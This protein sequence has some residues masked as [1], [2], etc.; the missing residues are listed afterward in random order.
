M[1]FSMRWLNDPEVNQYLETKWSDQTTDSIRSS[2]Q[3][4]R[5][6][7]QSFL[8]AI[9][10]KATD[11]HIR[12]IKIGPIHPHYKHADISCFIG[13]KGFWHRGNATEAIGL[14]CKYGFEQL[15]L[16]RIEA[17]AYACAVASWKALEKSGFKRE[18][19]LREQVILDDKYMDVYR[20]GL[21]IEERGIF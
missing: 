4:Q 3:S 6:N 17:G 9:I 10:D 19:V 14:V 20:Y 16:H 8:F 15:S 18:G 2:V 13:E 5:E 12:N 21:L 1:K 7:N 11:H